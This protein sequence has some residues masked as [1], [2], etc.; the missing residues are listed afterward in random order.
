MTTLEIVLIFVSIVETVVTVVLIRR[1]QKKLDE[2]RKKYED[3]I[4]EYETLI[5]TLPIGRNLL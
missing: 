3:A 2:A 5:R 4:S 1:K